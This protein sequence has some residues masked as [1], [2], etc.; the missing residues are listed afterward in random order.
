MTKFWILILILIIATGCDTNQQKKDTESFPI[1]TGKYLGQEEPGLTP[2]IFAPNIVSTGMSEINACFSPDYSE[3]FYSIVLPTRKFVIVSMMY[4]NNSWK[5]PEIAEFSGQYSDADPFITKDGKWLYFV[6]KR[7]EDTTK[8]EKKDW[9]IWRVEKVD[10]RWQNPEKLEN[11]INSESDDIYP[12]ISEK[13]TLYFSSGRYGK[14]NR[15]IY[16]SESSGDT[17]NDPIKMND[18]INGHWEGDIFISPKEDYMIFRS[19]GRKE[20]NGLFIT[21]NIN[22]HWS[23][24]KRMGSE[25]NMT[26][27]EFCP[28]V[29]PDGKYFFFTSANVVMK[30]ENS[31]ILT[32]NNIKEDFIKSYEHPQMGKNDIYWV[33]SE[34]IDSYRENN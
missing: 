23:T 33:D 25:I 10:G 2:E 28:I 30:S 31:R 24:P 8:T 14:N 32:Y 1:L 29:S 12:T 16:Y 9:D 5:K 4:E 34:I 22:D 17:F 26:G 15:D 20:G 19:Y 11:G 21:F 3:F 13:G 27:N 7:P 18:T 6:S